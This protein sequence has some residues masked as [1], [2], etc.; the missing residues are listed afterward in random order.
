M[1]PKQPHVRE[2]PLPC[3]AL[4][5]HLMLARPAT[6]G[7]GS[8]SSVHPVWSYSKTVMLATISPAAINYEETVSTLRCPYS[9]VR[10]RMRMWIHVCA[11]CRCGSVFV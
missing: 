1:V 7:L 10:L 9:C 2:Y 3:M 6:E 8:V 11:G 4:P 5:D